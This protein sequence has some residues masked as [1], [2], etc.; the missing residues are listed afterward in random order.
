[1][2]QSFSVA[3]PANQK[4]AATTVYYNTAIDSNYCMQGYSLAKINIDVVIPAG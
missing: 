1:M 4:Q 2:S 3:N